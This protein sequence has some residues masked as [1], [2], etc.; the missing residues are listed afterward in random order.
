M[1][2]FYQSKPFL[3]LIGTSDL[4][5]ISFP[6]YVKYFLKKYSQEHKPVIYIYWGIVQLWML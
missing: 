3:F 6:R 2:S 5:P 1:F 4:H